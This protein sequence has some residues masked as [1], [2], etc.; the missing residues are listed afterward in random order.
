MD[1]IRRAAVAGSFYP[2]EPAEL[3]KLIE[4]CFV[5]N[6]LG[7]L[8]AR[9]SRPSLLGGMVPHADDLDFA[10]RR[11]FADDRQHLGGADVETH[12]QFFI[13]PFRHSY[14]LLATAARPILV[15]P[16]AS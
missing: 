11:E 12:D 6:P 3:E 10:R 16:G 7:P 13:I 8:G 4:D 1:R 5:S 15:R 9:A 14:P 2:A